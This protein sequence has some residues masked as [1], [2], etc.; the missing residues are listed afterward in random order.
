[1]GTE[2]AE[3]LG[4]APAIGSDIGAAAAIRP[5][6]RRS[7]RP[8]ALA[9]ILLL[10]ARAGAAAAAPSLAQQLPPSSLLVGGDSDYVVQAGDSLTQ[11]SAR[12]GIDIEPLAASNGLSPTASLPVG[13]VL[14]IDNR[15]LV[16]ALAGEDFE[17]GI[18]IN[19]PQ[20]LLFLFGGGQLLA[21]HPVGLGRPGW[22]TPTGQFTIR[23]REVDK[24][25]V[26][27]PSIQA[28]MRR[29]GKTVPSVVPP[30]PENPLG[31]HWLGLSP[32]SCGIH[33][34]NAPPS[35]YRFQTHGCIRLHPDDVARLFERVELGTRVRIVYEPLLLGVLADGHVF[36]ELH[37]DP[38]PPQFD[39]AKMKKIA[40][41]AVPRRGA[42]ARSSGRISSSEAVVP[43]KLA[44][45][46]PSPITPVLISGVPD[47]EPRTWMSP[48]M[49]NSDPSSRMREPYSF[50]FS[51]SSCAPALP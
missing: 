38:G 49:T 27:P 4:V 23:E 51:S 36:L 13:Q 12:F 19:V 44:S 26:V 45:S 11:V 22:R 24:A 28:E 31:R 48:V 14:H 3:R 42:F 33:G 29:Q 39:T 32:G 5:R 37:A 46:A 21:H 7:L 15:H 34:T 43:M 17:E 1:M 50:A 47:G 40:M 16:P 9:G 41:W 25:W 30:G 10:F 6:V 20:R 8:F 35:V 2:I 18:L